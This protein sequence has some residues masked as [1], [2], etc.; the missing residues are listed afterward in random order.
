LNKRNDAINR[1]AVFYNGLLQLDPYKGLPSLFIYVDDSS[2]MFKPDWYVNFEYKREQERGLAFH[3]DLFSHGNFR[4]K[5]SKGRKI[6]VVIST[7]DFVEKDAFKIIDKERTRRTS[8]F[9]KLPVKDDFTKI[10]SLATDQFLVKRDLDL[11]TIIAGYHWFSDWGRDTMISLPGI[12]LVNGRFDEAKKILKSFALHVNQGMIPN[13]FPDNG[14]EPEYNTVDASLWFFIAIKKYLDYSHDQE[15]VLNELLPYLKEIIESHFMGTRYNI[16]V[17]QDHL[18]YAGQHGVQLT[19]MDAKTGD[20]VVTPRM[21]KAVEINALWYNALQI[22]SD[23]LKK[24]GE[25]I[26]SMKYRDHAQ[27]V[28]E[29]FVEKFL[30]PEKG[31]L[32]DCINGNDIDDSFRPNQ[33]FAISLPFPLLDKEQSLFILRMIEEKLLTP[34]GLRSLSSDDPKYMANY[35][36]NQYSRDAAYHQGTVWSWLLGPYLTA[37]IKLE[38]DVGKNAARKLLK[39]FEKHFQDACIGNVSEIFDGNAPFYPKGCIAQAWSAAEILRSYIEDIHG[40]SIH[41][42][43]IPAFNDDQIK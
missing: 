12:C 35:N 41:K 14:K 8:L 32:Y 38:G 9:D 25:G 33:L 13:R 23:L 39:N 20:W 10:L 36:G 18:L 7:S 11:K 1:S 22:I 19:W 34:F 17:D 40:Y 16:M 6:G 43:S 27:K 42:E 4:I 5:M 3:E 28:K 15:F 37:K 31:Y 2:F 24:N 21:G 29:S 26:E 30:S